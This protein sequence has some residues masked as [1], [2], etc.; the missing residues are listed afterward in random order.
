VA[1]EC[2]EEEECGIDQLQVAGPGVV[3]VG[4]G[5]RRRLGIRTRRHGTKTRNQTTYHST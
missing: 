5:Q 3:Q 1:E 4:I 2:V